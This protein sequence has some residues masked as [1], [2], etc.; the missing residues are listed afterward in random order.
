MTPA[1]AIAMLDRQMEKHGEPV[2][3]R[4]GSPSTPLPTTGFVRGYK[5]NEIVDMIQQ[6]DSHIVLS[7]SGLSGIF[8]AKLPT[9]D[10]KIDVA[11]STKN[12]ISA[13]PVRMAGVLVRMNLQVRGE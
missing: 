1:Q 4:R 12:I 10:D 3:L 8:A 11:G 5:A 2:V 13:E 6:G 9:S 7:P